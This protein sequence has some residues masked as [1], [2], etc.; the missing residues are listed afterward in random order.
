MKNNININ[1]MT[2]LNMVIGYPLSHTQSPVFHQAIYRRLNLNAVLLGFSNSNLQLLIKAIKTLGVELTAVTMPFKEKILAYLD[3][4]SPEVKILQA[5][6]TVIQKDHK[7]YGYNT[8]IAGIKYSLRH[9]NISHKKILVLGA[10]GAARAVGYFLHA[11]DANIYWYNR[12]PD[13]AYRLV[14]LFGGRIIINLTELE[15]FS[16]K[17]DLVIQTTPIGMS[18]EKN[19]SIFSEKLAKKIFHAD[20]IVFDLIYNPPKTLFLQQAESQGAKI[21]NGSEMFTGQALQQIELWTGRRNLDELHC[22]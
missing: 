13:K 20:Q 8:D 4:Q 10:G 7:L 5:A 12:S 21:I 18:P 6:N 14:E 9:E 19:I 16:E 11:H 3:E 17:F 15:S 1:S 2:K 22:N